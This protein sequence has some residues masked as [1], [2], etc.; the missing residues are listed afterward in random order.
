MKGKLI[1]YTLGRAST[2]ERVKF[3]KELSG[4]K[5]HSNGGKYK[6]RRQGLL[7]TIPH[8]KPIRSVI[9]V[10]EKNKNKVRRLLDKYEATYYMFS[11]HVKP[12]DL[13]Y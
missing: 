3:K 8:L 5:D 1:C 12:K 10:E 9:I 4:Y 11:I 2:N 6:Y 7:S 13:V